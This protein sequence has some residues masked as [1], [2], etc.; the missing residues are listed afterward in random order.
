[1]SQYYKPHR[2]PD[3]NYGG[4]KFPL[5]RSRIELFFGCPKC[6][7]IDN[8][9]GVARPPGYPFTLNS[10]VD[11]LLKREFDV[12]RAKGEIHPLMKEYGIDAIPFAHEQ[13]D[14]WRDA[15]KRGV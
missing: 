3:W 7:Y 6:F 4:K 12:Q 9:L 1:M 11:E 2:N 13:M 15:L 5:S 8:K 10:A 14:A